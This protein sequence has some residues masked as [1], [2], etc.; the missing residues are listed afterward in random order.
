MSK[1]S[2]NG[3]SGNSRIFV[4]AAWNND[5]HVFII[6]YSIWRNSWSLRPKCQLSEDDFWCTPFPQT[7]MC[8]E[9][10]DPEGGHEWRHSR[11]KAK[12]TQN[13]LVVRRLTGGM[14]YSCHGILIAV[15]GFLLL[16][17]LQRT[18][19]VERCRA[20]PLTLSLSHVCCKRMR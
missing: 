9:L 20:L 18:Y 10:V 2:S 11:N 19:F 3:S 4:I 1:E 13:L 8:T 7:G 14:T 5:V 16:W 17:I 15:H 12:V 6:F